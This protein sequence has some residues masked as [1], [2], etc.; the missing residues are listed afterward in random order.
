MKL[1]QTIPS[2]DQNTKHGIRDQKHLKR[3]LNNSDVKAA[4]DA[5]RSRFDIPKN[6]KWYRLGVTDSAT[7]EQGKYAKQQFECEQSLIFDQKDLSGR[8]RRKSKKQDFQLAVAALRRMPDVNLPVRFQRALEVFVLYGLFDRMIHTVP[9][10]VYVYSEGKENRLFIEVFGDTKQKHLRTVWQ[11]F[12]LD[13]VIKR[14]KIKGGH[15]RSPNFFADREIFNRDAS[16]GD[17]EHDYDA[18]NVKKHRFQ[19]KIT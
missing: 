9:Y 12:L 19:K 17:P 4:I 7:P 16:Q 6:G 3:F 13:N 14:Y 8:I 2:Q 11:T 10:A 1:I 15:L 18:I 5:I